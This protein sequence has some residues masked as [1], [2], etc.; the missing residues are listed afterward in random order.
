M[1]ITGILYIY[2]VELITFMTDIEPIQK[3]ALS[4]IWIFVIHSYPDLYK[5]M[6]KG[7]TLALGIQSK[8]VYVHMITY[9]LVYPLA[10]FYFVYYLNLG[11]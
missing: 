5:G 8:V 3:E 10:V 7:V 1:I 2:S 11:I 9:W 4:A 6:L